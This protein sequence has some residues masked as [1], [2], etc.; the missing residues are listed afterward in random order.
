MAQRPEGLLIWLIVPDPDRLPAA[1]LLAALLDDRLCTEGATARVLVSLP[2]GTALPEAVGG[3]ELLHVPIPEDTHDDIPT[4]LDHWRPDLVIWLSGHIR[5]ALMAALNKAEVP[6]L[7]A[8]AEER[9]LSDPRWSLRA[10]QTRRAL[11]GFSAFHA[12]SAGAGRRLQRLGADASRIRI[13]EPLQEGRMALPCDIADRDELAD[14][15][16]GRPIWL[17]AM[18]CADELEQVLDA[19]RQASRMAHRLLLILVPN[20]PGDSD[21]FAETLT[22]QDWRFQ[23]WSDKDAPRDECQVLLA[24]TYGDMGLWYRLSPV[25]FMAGSLQRGMKG[26]DPYEPATHGSA[27]IYGPYVAGHLPAYTRLSHA[28]AAR[29]IRDAGGLQASV[30]MLLAPDQAASMAAA[31]WSTVTEGAEA[32]DRVLDWTLAQLEERNLL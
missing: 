25:T 5:N 31:A 13:S 15:L 18:V 27:I 29:I 23:R 19:Q 10:L 16:A 28:G 12:A 8:G 32:T 26:H 11:E 9:A 4:F 30:S 20:A 14:V 22:A 7:L 6:V 2:D 24:D 17:A 1:H 21:A 3:P